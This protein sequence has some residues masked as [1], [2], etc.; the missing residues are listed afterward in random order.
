MRRSTGK[1]E[2]RERL[3]RWVTVH[4][5]ATANSL[6]QALSVWHILHC[7]CCYINTWCFFSRLLVC[8][9][10]NTTQQHECIKCK[11]HQ[12]VFIYIH[13]H[14]HLS[15]HSKWFI[16]S[17]PV[18]IIPQEYTGSYVG[19]PQKLLRL[20][21][22]KHAIGFRP[23]GHQAIDKVSN[24]MKR[25]VFVEGCKINAGFEGAMEPLWVTRLCSRNLAQAFF[26]HLAS[27]SVV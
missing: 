4:K 24:N 11:F 21:V 12:S 22:T 18:S 23:N 3:S 17:S 26:F 13:I 5:E 15:S 2:R 27:L 1:W 10:Q 25:A 6:E 9:Y 20:D 14:I 8:A 16:F 7:V 19:S